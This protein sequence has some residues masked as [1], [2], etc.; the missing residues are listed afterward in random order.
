[1]VIVSGGGKELGDE[2]AR[3]EAEIGRMAADKQV[4]IIGCNCIGVFDGETRLDTFFQTHER[5]VRPRKGPIA[6][7][8]QSG[9]VG[10]AFL[11]AVADVGVSRF[12]SYGNRI[13]VD[14]ADLI[15]WLA[16]DEATRVIACYVEGFENGRAFL[17]AARRASMK[18]PIVIY[19]AGRSREGA[20]AAASHTGFLG[21]SYKVALG[22]FCQAGLI[23][24]DSFEELCATARTLALQ[25][26]AKG[27]RIGLISNGAGTMVQCLDLAARYGLELADLRP[28]TRDRMAGAFPAY[29][30]VHNPVDVT[31]SATSADYEL[32]MA[33][34]LEDDGTDIVMP[35]FVFQDTPLDEGIVD[36]VSRL[37]RSTG[38]PIVCGATGGDYS[39]W[40]ARMIWDCGVP[41]HSSVRDWVAGASGLCGGKPPVPVGE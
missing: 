17:R 16:D 40:M 19:K 15:G 5:M 27:G 14:E 6:M 35:W 7:I 36:V 10:A 1:M 32:G 21:G 30:Q 34:L 11:E 12:V 2:S 29:Y 13:D 31:G 41:V 20:G 28:A 25:P 22:A 39:R 3:L 9:T 24:V 33:A 38:K 26:L 8:T 37:H 4:R 18:K 23:A